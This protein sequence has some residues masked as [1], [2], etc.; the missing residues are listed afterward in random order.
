MATVADTGTVI[1][2]GVANI[3]A[4][5]MVGLATTATN[6]NNSAAA[7]DAPT[8]GDDDDDEATEE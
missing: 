1:V 3:G 7:T 5:S 8:K 2:F 6:S 4:P